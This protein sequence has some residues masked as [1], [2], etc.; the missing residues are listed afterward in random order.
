[1]SAERRNQDLLKIQT[2]C[3]N[4]GGKLSIKTTSGNPLSKIVLLSKYKTVVDQSYPDKINASVTITI[5]LPPRYPF[6]GGEPKVNLNPIVY[7]PNVYSGGTICL[8]KK[9]MPTEYLDLF[10][11]RVLAIITYEPSVIDDKSA[12][13]TDAA[14]WYL[15]R[16]KSYPSYFPSDSIT[17]EAEKPKPSIAWNNLK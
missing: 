9:W 16:I 1:M 2:L 3:N 7:H 4:S 10:V 13:N 14:R 6:N 8:G 11:K 15:S 17:F 5:D 12:A